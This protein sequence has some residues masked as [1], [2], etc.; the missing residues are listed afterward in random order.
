VL[1]RT[2]RVLDPAAGEGELVLSLITELRRQNP[3]PL[4]VV[5]FD[6]SPGALA[7]A[8]ARVHDAFPNVAVEVRPTD[9]LSY[10][11]R[12]NDS[13]D[14]SGSARPDGSGYDLIIANPPYVRTQVLGAARTERIARRF[15]LSGRVDLY[16]AFVLGISAC[17]APGGA[18]GVIVSNRFMSTRAGAAVRDALLRELDV[19]HVWDL[20]DTRLF[21]AA[22][23]PAVLLLGKP[24][25]GARR[26]T[27][28]FTSIYSVRAARGAVSCRDTIEALD[29]QGAISLPDGTSFAVEQGHLLIDGDAGGIWR[30]TTEASSEWLARVHAAAWGTFAR[31]G[32]VRV[33]VK[34][35]ADRVFLRS[36]WGSLPESERPELLRRV[37]THHVARRYRPGPAG[38]DRW[39]LY[40]HEVRDGRTVPVDLARV[41]R[42]A[43]YLEG[44][45]ELLESRSYVTK[46]G[47][48]WYEVWVPQDAGAWYLPKLVF[49]DIAEHPCFWI[50]LEGTVVNGDCYWLACRDESSQPLLWLALAVANSSFIERYY[51]LRFRN[52]LYA[53]RRRFMTQYVEQFPLPDPESDEGRELV[54]LAREAYARA[55]TGE[56]SDIEA[57]IDRS[58]HRAFRVEAR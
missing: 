9:F 28:R 24:G 54:A 16:H 43:Q 4:S 12:R 17:L 44:R 25:D 53:G 1:D 41:P 39:I 31:I 5:A 55:E 38:S 21:D 6:T 26:G 19:I 48:A 51:D 33:G 56:M 35:T 32:R 34:T 18:A 7:V 42:T 52:K 50:D 40:P 20:G 45:H 15:G 29:R 2:V 37:T 22:V 58:V 3:V 8:A 46:A 23:L 13:H 14:G 49:R 10:A 36:D 27:A 57:V 47:R 11:L 30:L